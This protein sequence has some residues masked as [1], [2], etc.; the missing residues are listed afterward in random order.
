[1]ITQMDIIDIEGILEEAE[2]AKVDIFLKT[3]ALRDLLKL[4][5]KDKLPFD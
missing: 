4:I 1:M 3:T 5:D 2:N